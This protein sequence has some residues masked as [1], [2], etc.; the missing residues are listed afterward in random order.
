M[1]YGC[2]AEVKTHLLRADLTKVRDDTCEAAAA[3]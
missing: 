3:Y 1:M 2:D